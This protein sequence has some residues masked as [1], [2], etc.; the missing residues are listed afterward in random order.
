MR[1]LKYTPDYSRRHFL[2]Q[3]SA[4]IL[5]TGVLMSAYEALAQDGDASKAYPDELRS[6]EGYTNGRI[7]TGDTIDSSNV[8]LV[9]DLLDPIRYQQVIQLERKLNIVPTETDILRLSPVDYMEA[10][11]R[12]KGQAKFAADGNVVTQSGE[13]WIGG[14]PFP[15]PKTAIEVFA[16]LTLSW[17]RHD[18][19]FYVGKE[20]DMDPDGHVQYRYEAAFAELSPVGRVTVEP[21]PYW[22]EHKD[23]LRFNSI[24]FTSPADIKGTSFLNVWP[25]DQN[26]FPDLFGYLPAFK[27]IRRFPTNQRFEPLIAGNTLYLSDVWAAG[28]PFL[29]WGNYR[30]V[31]RG[32][33]LASMSGGWAADHPNWEHKTHGGVESKSWFDTP[34]DFIPEALVVEAEPVKYPRAPI[35]KKWVWFDARTMLPF[36]MASFDR[37][38]QIYRSFDGCFGVYE[39]NGKSVS[40]GRHPYWSWTHFHAHNI[41]TNRITRVEQVQQISGGLRMAV[42]D[43]TVYEKYLTQTALRR[44]GT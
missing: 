2:Q 17:G 10:T 31:G 23:K 16:G 41:Q 30:I 3:T 18:I 8:E 5:A 44:M 33:A 15:D 37:R 4:G 27:R 43:P 39:A 40:D 12:H 19:T 20:E 25:Y 32:P 29:T 26:E 36:A 9:K 7:K 14:N 34:V 11:F 21:K 28:D 13:P 24:I 22:P 1:V 35:G 42:N 6:I 38:G